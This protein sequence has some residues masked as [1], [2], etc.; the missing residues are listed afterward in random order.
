MTKRLV[1]RVAFINGGARGI[2][3]ASAL[4]LASE[5]ARVWITSRDQAAM[6]EALAEAR[7]QGLSLN[8]LE[9]DSAQSKAI[10]Q[11]ISYVHHTE[12]RIDVLINNA[13][14]SLQTPGVFEQQSDEDWARVLDLNI[15]GTVWACRYTLPLMKA[16]GG[17]RVVNVG[18]K[19]GQFGSRR[20]GGGA[21]A[22]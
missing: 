1:D 19:A 3:R 10:R 20:Q 5:G 9:M 11:A 21:A 13:G 17:G 15:M 7:A 14:G 16:Q 6:D 2:G 8:I 22:Q 12:G 4:R 18:S